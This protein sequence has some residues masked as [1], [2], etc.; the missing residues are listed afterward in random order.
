MW[1]PGGGNTRFRARNGLTGGLSA[2]SY[3]ETCRRHA[4][5][6]IFNVTVRVYV[7][8]TLSKSGQKWLCWR[9][10]GPK[11]TSRRSYRVKFGVE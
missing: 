10:F 7:M 4:V 11:S 5:F 6:E 1:P 2:L 9:V 3:E 8:N